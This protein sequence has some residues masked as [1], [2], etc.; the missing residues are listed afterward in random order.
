MVTETVGK[1]R[2]LDS[3]VLTESS[4]SIA[5]FL[6]T[7]KECYLILFN[8][9]VQVAK[10][11]IKSDKSFTLPRTKIVASGRMRDSVINLELT[12]D[13]TKLFELLKYSLYVGE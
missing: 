8:P 10:Y 2:K 12:E 7:Y 1:F 3:D 9:G 13:K 11:E 4:E 5:T 6:T